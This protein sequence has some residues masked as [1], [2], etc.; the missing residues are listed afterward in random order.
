MTASRVEASFDV[1]A[2]LAL[3]DTQRA[4]LLARTGPRVSAV[5]QD[6]RSQARNRDLALTRLAERIAAGLRTPRARTATRPTKA[7]KER[8]LASKRAAS[9]RKRARRPPRADAD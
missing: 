7:S 3:S 4:R 2:S 5:A 9:D 1:A 6:A 8:R